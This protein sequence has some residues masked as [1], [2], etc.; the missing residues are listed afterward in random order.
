MSVYI[1]PENKNAQAIMFNQKNHRHKKDPVID[2]FKCGSTVN[3]KSF[4][5]L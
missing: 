5:T 3:A 4:E 1:I 2:L